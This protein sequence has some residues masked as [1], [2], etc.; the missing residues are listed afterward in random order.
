MDGNGAT[1]VIANSPVTGNLQG[2][3]N[4]AATEG[5]GNTVGGNLQ[6]QDNTGPSIQ[7]GGSGGRRE[8]AMREQCRDH[9]RREFREKEAGP[10]RLALTE[11]W[12]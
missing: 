7:V 3:N 5:V 9:R 10:V 1:T 11:A 8:P 6:V 4:T 2:R 12:R